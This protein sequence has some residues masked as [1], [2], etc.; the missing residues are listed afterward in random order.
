MDFDSANQE[1]NAIRV[2]LWISPHLKNDWYG[3]TFYLFSTNS[4]P[5]SVG[6]KKKKLITIPLSKDCMTEENVHITWRKTKSEWILK[7]LTKYTSICASELRM[8]VALST[9]H[10]LQKFPTFTFSKAAPSKSI[11]ASGCSKVHLLLNSVSERST[12][13]ISSFIG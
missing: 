6:I 11:A 8:P 5:L 13:P 3:T 7:D 9:V 1:S 2:V 10:Y 12:E 4:I